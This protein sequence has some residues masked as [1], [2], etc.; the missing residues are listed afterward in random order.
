[1]NQEFQGTIQFN[2]MDLLEKNTDPP[3]QNE[4]M[5][6]GQKQTMNPMKNSVIFQPA[7]VVFGFATRQVQDS[8]KKNT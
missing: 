2:L 3:P 4:R 7:M 6:L 5:T 8:K 1:M